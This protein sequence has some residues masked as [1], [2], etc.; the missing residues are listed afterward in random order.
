M[1]TMV[2][3]LYNKLFLSKI[4]VII[5]LLGVI[6]VSSG[7]SGTNNSA[8]KYYTGYNSWEMSFLSDSPPSIFYYDSQAEYGSDVNTIPIYV[9]VENKGSSDSYG[10][11][12]IH[13]FDPNIVAVEGYTQGYP[14]YSGAYR[15]SGTAFGGWISGNDFSANVVD[16][17]VGES[18]SLSFGL[19]NI[20]GR[21]GISF[22]S[23]SNDRNGL[24]SAIGFGATSDGTIMARVAQ[25]RV[26]SA[27]IPITKTMFG[28]YHWNEGWL[29]TLELE[30]RNPNNPGGGMDVIEFPATIMTLPP[31][32]EQFNQRMMITSCFDYATHASTMVCIDPEPYSNVKKACKPQTVGLGGGQGAPV[33]ITSIE[34]KPGR[35]R[36]T[37][38]IN[39]H[40]NKKGT[41]DELYDYFSLY[42]CDPASGA[43]VKTTDKNIVY[44]GYVY[45]SDQDITMTCIPDQTIRLD[46]AG[47]GQITCSVEFPEGIASSAYQAPMEIELWY[48]Y[49]K[50]IY[51]DMIIKKI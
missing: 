13:G 3:E 1:N 35:G 25:S 23:L 6:L 38:T 5:A 21:Q 4:L 44:V 9:Q 30:G 37:F 17:P 47:N 27:L 24:F 49:S 32:L 39:I 2:R 14:G 33:A 28:V 26:G 50:T 20:N 12:F 36:T 7:C 43:T 31:S 29:K 8:T 11:I 15:G 16:L 22:S 34:Q 48:G 10:A 19:S 45:L 40:H 41:Y 46:T 42:K 18:G 51:R